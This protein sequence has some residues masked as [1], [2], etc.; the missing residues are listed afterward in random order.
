MVASQFKRETGVPGIGFSFRSRSDTQLGK[1]G[2]WSGLKPSEKTSTTPKII[3]ITPPKS[4]TPV[5]DGVIEEP[6]RAPSQKQV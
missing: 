1:V 3:K 2:E 4:I 6:M 5:R